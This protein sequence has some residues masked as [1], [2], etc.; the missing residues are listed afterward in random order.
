MLP[1]SCPIHPVALRIRGAL[2]HLITVLLVVFPY[3]HYLSIH[4]GYIMSWSSYCGV[5]LLFCY[6]RIVFPF[7][8]PP[9]F[10]CL[11]AMSFPVPLYSP[12][13]W[14]LVSWIFPTATATAAMLRYFWF[15]IM[16]KVA[17]IVVVSCLLF[18]A[19]IC[20]LPS[21]TPGVRLVSKSCQEV[22]MK[23]ATA[24]LLIG[25]FCRVVPCSW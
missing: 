3:L 25:H 2:V 7:L 20:S 23:T 18:T 9:P 24:A 4:Q 6:L 19:L 21:H 13:C 10:R 17:G 16:L 15:S 14:R 5:Y 11:F 1:S 22:Y 8:F 12:V